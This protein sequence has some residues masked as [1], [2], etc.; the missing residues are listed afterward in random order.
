MNKFRTDIQGLRAFAVMAV[1]LFHFNPE[2]L[3]GGFIGV[4]IFFVISGY[5]M[6][7]IVISGVN[8]GSFSLKRF[9]IARFVR[10]VPALLLLCG[11]VTILGFAILNLVDATELARH[12]L[13]SV[14]FFSNITYWLESGYFDDASKENWLLHTWS[15]SVEWQFY[16]IYPI[17]VLILSKLFSVDMIGRLTVFAI[18][19]GY[20]VSIWASNSMPSA[21]YFWLP[22][23]AW[24]LLIGGLAFFYPLKLKS[25]KTKNLLEAIGFLILIICTLIVS[26][27]VNWPG[28]IAMLPVAA[29]LLIILA[30]NQNS[31]L[32]GNFVAQTIGKWSYSIYLWHWPLVV[33]IIYFELPKP[34][35]IFALTAS[36]FFGWFSYHFCEN[37]FGKNAISGKLWGPSHVLFLAT[38]MLTILATLVLQQGNIIKRNIDAT[39]PFIAGQRYFKD[40]T[41]VDAPDG[42]TYFL[43][44]STKNNFDYLAIGD[45]NLSHYIYGI[46]KQS[47]K[48]VILSWAG[49]CLSLPNYITKPVERYM[50]KHWENYCENNYKNIAKYPSKP[51]LLVQQW[52][53]REMLCTQEPCD[54]DSSKENYFNLLEKQFDSLVTYAGETRPIVIIGQVPAPTNSVYRCMKGFDTQSC[55]RFSNEQENKRVITNLFLESVASNYGNVYF[56]NPFDAVCDNEYN[57]KIV[58]DNKSLFHD[59]GHLSAFGSK[60]FWA[61]I[62]EKLSE[63]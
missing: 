55:K 41:L 7:S 57:C 56:I 48:N 28:S 49:S 17:V 15:L 62:S 52:Q 59:E 50:N 47:S 46:E 23:R 8:S 27:N 34:I 58:I 39:E 20:A 60:I 16:L 21:A 14:A 13:S 9:Y 12:A 26:E 6:T 25:Q 45:S 22:T 3:T 33:A 29:T 42:N 44:N 61:F 19:S 37:R 54:I 18:L 32:T 35:W 2:L 51:V 4:D 1:V 40:N 11:V 5:L 30:N 63:L 38:F 36:L 24:E 53:E 10:I 43:N 31:Y